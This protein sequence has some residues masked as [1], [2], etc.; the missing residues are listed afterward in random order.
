LHVACQPNTSDNNFSQSAHCKSLI[1][2]SQ[3]LH[4]EISYK[5]KRKNIHKY[6]ILYFVPLRSKSDLIG[7][8]RP[9][10]FYAALCELCNS[11]INK[12]LDT[13]ATSNFG[14]RAAATR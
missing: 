7:E 6:K 14:E 5:K 1:L 4:A 11:L 8:Y 2:I 10:V 12:E 9:K 3:A 13:I